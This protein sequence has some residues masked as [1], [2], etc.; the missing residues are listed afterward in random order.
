MTFTDVHVHLSA[1]PSPGNGCLLS[2]RMR[3][4]PVFRM[5]AAA[6]GLPVD[7]PERANAA[8]LQK[9]RNELAASRHAGRAVILGMDGAYDESGE[10]DEAHTDFLVSNDCVFAA[11]ETDPRFLP[12]VSINPRRKDAV[13]EL[14][15]CVEKGAALVKILANSQRFDPA[16]SRNRGFWRAMAQKR[17]PLLSHVGYEFSLIGQDQSVGDLDRMI[18]A[19]EAGVTVIAAHGCST[20]LFVW[21]KHFS[22]MLRLIGRYPH[23]YV[24]VSALSLFNR[25]GALMRIRRHPEVWPRLLFGT[26]YPLP[27]FAY[28]CL[29]AGS[30]GGFR[31][32][33]AADNRFDRQFQVL[34]ALGIRLITDFLD[35]KNAIK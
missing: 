9:L 14:S 10:L 23:F 32:A 26:D 35:V 30:W 34:D 20:G 15:R 22:T 11:A 17:I 4:S 1:L 24:D 28:P 2:P 27:V 33:R 12:G 25:V 21:E 3:K 18:P 13:D 6:Q 16:D 8:Y 7:E 29:L 5:V 31:A 19:L